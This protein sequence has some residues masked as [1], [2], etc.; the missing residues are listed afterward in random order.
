MKKTT[1]LIV[2]ALLIQAGWFL[3]PSL[4]IQATPYRY[5]ERQKA[6]ADWAREKTWEARMAFDSERKLLQTHLQRRAEVLLTLF[7]VVDGVGIYFVWKHGRKQPV[8]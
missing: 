1:L 5:A 6:M 4:N 7:I 8:A 3:Y 2:L